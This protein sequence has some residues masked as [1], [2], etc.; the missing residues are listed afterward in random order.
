VRS[1]IQKVPRR[2][3]LLTVRFVA[4]GAISSYTLPKSI[5]K[6]CSLLHAFLPI[7]MKFGALNDRNVLNV[8]ELRENRHNETHTLQG[9][10]INFYAYF[11]LFVKFR[12]GGLH[13]MLIMIREFHGNRSRES[14][15][16]HRG[17][18]KVIIQLWC[19]VVA[20]VC[21]I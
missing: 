13:V 2:V 17:V 21:R 10:G 19:T 20:E 18:N 6:V 1:S 3:V 9:G 5:R 15:T 12:I 11:S 14:R 4:V 8:C 7:L 16:Y